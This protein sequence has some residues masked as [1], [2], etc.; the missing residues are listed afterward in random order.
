M[1]KTSLVESDIEGGRRLV[2]ALSELDTHFRVLAAFW[3]YLPETMEWRLIIATPLIDQKGPFSSYTH[4]QRVLR[5]LNP[6]PSITLQ[7]I[8][9]VS[10]RDKLA[11]VIKRAIRVPRGSLGV[12]VGSTRIDDT[13]VEDAY[14]YPVIPRA[15]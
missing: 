3:I 1:V 10:P 15:A 7:D 5:S 9:V 8:S 2:K 11:K 6:P 12:R 4:V 14:V 13:F